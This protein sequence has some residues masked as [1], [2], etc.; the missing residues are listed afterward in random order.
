MFRRIN[1]VPAGCQTVD[2]VKLDVYVPMTVAEAG[3]FEPSDLISGLRFSRPFHSTNVN[4]SMFFVPSP[5]FE[6]RSEDYE[7]PI[8][9]FELT[10]QF[11]PGVGIEPTQPVLET[12]SP[13]LGTC[14]GICST[15]DRTRTCNLLIRS[16]LHCPLC[17]RSIVGVR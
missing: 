15:P 6:L 8:L 12:S 1:G 5:R 11:A 3:G 14:P 10:G 4:T 2:F 13:I 17:Y 16:Q 7:S 9:P